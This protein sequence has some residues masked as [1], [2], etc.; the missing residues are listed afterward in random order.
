M[1][2]EAKSSWCAPTAPHRD[3][4]GGGLAGRLLDALRDPAYLIDASGLTLHW[5]EA[6]A[7][8]TGYSASEMVGRPASSSRLGLTDAAGV[9]LQADDYLG[10]RALLQGRPID[11][12]GTLRRGDGERV[13]VEARC[14]PVRDEGGALL[15]VLVVLRDASGDAA[16]RK[17]LRQA[18][19]AAER[20][21]LT[22]LANRRALDRMLDIQLTVQ[23]CEGRPFCLVMADI[24][25]FKAVNDRWGHACGDRVLAAFADLLRGLSRAEDLV[26]RLGGEE[27]VVLL[28]DAPLEVA[29]R[30]AERLRLATPDAG[31]PEMAPRRLTASFGV[32]EAVPGDTAS[33]L[34]RRADAALY[35]AK[36][37]GRD[38]VE[39]AAIDDA[40]ADPPPA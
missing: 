28:P 10:K 23:A 16:L 24:D 13:Q 8:F 20:D 2:A 27:F 11:R 1:N 22:G 35:R 30:V 38:R 4:L 29:M 33:R 40:P 6:A 21:P 36:A 3:A 15:G 7:R 9:P 25:H 34:L 12:M 26:A 19:E 17:A 5:N 39:A 14:S 18:R 31:P 32:A 37:G